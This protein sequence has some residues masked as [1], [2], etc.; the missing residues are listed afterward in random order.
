ML[1][2][3]NMLRGAPTRFAVSGLS[4]SPFP[5]NKSDEHSDKVDF[6]TLLTSLYFPAQ[7]C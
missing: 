2:S 4:V 6:V 3:G 1:E 5:M 7:R